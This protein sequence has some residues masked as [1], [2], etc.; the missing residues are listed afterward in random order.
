MRLIHSTKAMR[1]STM[2]LA[3]P[4]TA[5]MPTAQPLGRSPLR[6]G[7]RASMMTALIAGGAFA[8]AADRFLERLAELRAGHI[9]ARI[10]LPE[11]VVDAVELD[12]LRLVVGDEFVHVGLGEIVEIDAAAVKDAALA[13]L[14]H[15]IEREEDCGI[16][17]LRILRDQHFVIL[18][19][20]RVDGDGEGEL[21]LIR[22]D[23]GITARAIEHQ[24]LE[25]ARGDAILAAAIEH[26][27]RLMPELR[28]I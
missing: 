19:L 8:L 27:L 1:T 3:S 24:R 22:V 21:A 11:F 6:R 15:E 2:R 17:M 26:A 18:E 4:A 9:D 12:A 16:G 5:A 25:L 20:R 7:G 28:N 14:G 23:I 10:V 13:L